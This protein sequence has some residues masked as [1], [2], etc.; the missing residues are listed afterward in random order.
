MKTTRRKGKA[1]L[2]PNG[3]C[4]ECGEELTGLQI[5][6]CGPECARRVYARAKRI[7]LDA[8]A[9]PNTRCLQCE[10]KVE[11]AGQWFCGPDCSAE[12]RHAGNIRP[13]RYDRPEFF[14]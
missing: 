4:R 13:S 3:Y 11:Q 5:R 1:K 14:T 8:Y 12:W 6:W 2:R 7:A 10:K 9:P